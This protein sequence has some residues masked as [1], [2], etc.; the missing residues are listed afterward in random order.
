MATVQEVV[1]R[2]GEYLGILRIGQSLQAQDNT[3]ITAAYNE[4]YADLKVDSIAS[5]ASDG[6]IPDEVVQHVAALIAENCLNTYSVPDNRYTRI[7]NAVSTAK[8]EIRRLVLPAY[9]STNDPTD[10]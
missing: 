8:R 9:E 2:A 6:T 3:R 5:W 7:K 10:Y 4:V 1:N